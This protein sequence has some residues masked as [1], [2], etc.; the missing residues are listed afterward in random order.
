MERQGG[1]GERDWQ[2]FGDHDQ[3]CHGGD[4][5]PKNEYYKE[6]NSCW[7]QETTGDNTQNKSS[8]GKNHAFKKYDQFTVYVIIL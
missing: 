2:G 4:H 7:H 5:N 3:D 1:F 8:I 6:F